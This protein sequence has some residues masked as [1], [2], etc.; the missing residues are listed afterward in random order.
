VQPKPGELLASVFASAGLQAVFRMLGLLQLKPLERWHLLNY[1]VVTYVIAAGAAAIAC[2]WVA[3]TTTA[4]I[5]GILLGVLVCYAACDGY[6]SLILHPWSA[7]WSWAI[8]LGAKAL[9]V[10]AYFSYGFAIARIISVLFAAF[11]GW[12]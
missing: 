8:N 5:V 1:E 4:R 12:K 9:F 7:Q 10:L 11:K 6:S 2:L 3:R